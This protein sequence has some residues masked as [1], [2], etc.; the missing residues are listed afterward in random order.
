MERNGR[1]VDKIV[2]RWKRMEVCWIEWK[3]LKK[4]WKKVEWNDR[5]VEVNGRR[6]DGMIG[7]LMGM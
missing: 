3:K 4:E 7:S 1:R 6:L 5:N 2:R